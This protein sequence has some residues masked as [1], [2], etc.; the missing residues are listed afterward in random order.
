[1]ISVGAMNDYGH[2]GDKLLARLKQYTEHIFRTDLHGNIRMVSNGE[3]VDISVP[4]Q[5][6]E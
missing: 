2:P 1:M 3:K 5:M 6:G 4:V